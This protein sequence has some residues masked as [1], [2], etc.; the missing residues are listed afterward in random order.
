M[1]D[2][3]SAVVSELNRQTHRLRTML[4]L[5]RAG[6]DSMTM[7]VGALQAIAGSF[8]AREPAYNT[9]DKLIALGLVGKKHENH[10]DNS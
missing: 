1:C 9:A 2:N 8:S 3:C 10:P 7:K 6:W 4:I 5:E